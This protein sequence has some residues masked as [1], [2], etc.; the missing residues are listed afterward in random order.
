VAG[1]EAIYSEILADDPGEAKAIGGLA[2]LHVAAGRMDEAKALLETAPAAPVGKEQEPSVVAAWAALRLAEQASTVG[3]LAPLE[4][5]I[6]A[7]PDDHQA[8]FDL[9]VAQSAKGERDA[10]ADHLLE[11]IRRDRKW[12]DEAARKQLLQLFE[13]WGLMDPASVAARRKLSAVWF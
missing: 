6:A 3:E 13:A 5:A 8:R 11:I 4:Q 7:N 1:A 12:N 9:A 2:K 10:A